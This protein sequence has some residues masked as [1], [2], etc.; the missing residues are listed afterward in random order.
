MGIY[1]A[2]WRAVAELFRGE[3]FSRAWIIQE[4][5]LA[6]KMVLLHGRK[7]E[8]IGWDAFAEAGEI[9]LDP[10]LQRCLFQTSLLGAPL[11]DMSVILG[12]KNLKMLNEI[13]QAFVAGDGVSIGLLM[14]SSK[15]FNATNRKDKVFGLLG[16]ATL[17][18]RRALPVNLR[19]CDRWVLL[20]AARFALLQ[21]SM[22]LFELS[23][24][25]CTKSLAAEELRMPS[26]WPD[27]LSTRLQ[28]P[29]VDGTWY[30]AGTHLTSQVE[31]VPN[32]PETLKIRGTIIDVVVAGLDEEVNILERNVQK[33]FR[34]LKRFVKAGAIL[35]QHETVRQMYPA[36]TDE[37][38]WR[39]MLGDFGRS[40]V[41]IPDEELDGYIEAYQVFDIM[42]TIGGQQMDP[43]D[44]EDFENMEFIFGAHV[45]GKRLCRTRRGYLGVVPRGT[46]HGDFICIISGASTPYVIHLE[47]SNNLRGREY[48]VMGNCYIQ[49][50]M[51]GELERENLRSEMLYFR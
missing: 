33:H 31:E 41:P 4:V 49:G 20:R 17:D 21:G 40:G 10:I 37:A 13:R 7:H 34:S 46:R 16:L 25:G 39:T 12:I 35:A 36:G 14:A 2:N 22:E 26:W 18:A 3:W 42:T 5:A 15:E 27:F 43:A 1:D 19:T 47:L 30:R 29:L 44:A 23:G 38:L 45:G 51:L 50:I 28:R 9:L 24:A 11:P 48:E 6:R 32:E 8:E